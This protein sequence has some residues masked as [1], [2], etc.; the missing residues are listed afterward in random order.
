MRHF[1]NGFVE[2]LL[3]AR[4]STFLMRTRA[5]AKYHT[6]ELYYL[7]S[8]RHPAFGYVSGWLSLTTRTT[9]LAFGGSSPYD[10][11]TLSL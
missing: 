8:G 5:R 11:Q 6:D 4:P 10:L 7:D 2:P 9:S 1:S 3:S